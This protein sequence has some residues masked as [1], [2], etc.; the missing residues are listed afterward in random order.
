MYDRGSILRQASFSKDRCYTPKWRPFL[1]DFVPYL[2]ASA[3]SLATAYKKG[4]LGSR[5]SARPPALQSQY[6]ILALPPPRTECMLPAGLIRDPR[7]A[8]Y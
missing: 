8:Q 7:R 6:T 4:S 3:G 5:Q 2:S 1:I